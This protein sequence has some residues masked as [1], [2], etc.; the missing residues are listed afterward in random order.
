MIGCVHVEAEGQPLRGP[1]VA[2]A[3]ARL[4]VHG[5]IDRAASGQ[6]AS[7]ESVDHADVAPLDDGC[8]VGPVVL[9]KIQLS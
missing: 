3:D 8:L 6:A 7:D 1:S 5:Q 9:E 4:H 2:L